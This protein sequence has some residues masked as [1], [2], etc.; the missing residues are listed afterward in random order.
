MGR[1]YQQ[2]RRMLHC[3]TLKLFISKSKLGRHW[4]KCCDLKHCVGI[5]TFKK[6]LT[7]LVIL[8]D[9]V[10]APEAGARERAFALSLA[11]RHL[12]SQMYSAPGQKVGMIQDAM[13]ALKRL[14]Y[15]K[16]VEDCQKL[17]LKVEKTTTA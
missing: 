5:L 6:L 7:N 16:G 1:L 15:H 13:G 9:K 3:K 14:G 10:A 4:T 2:W 8:A 11:C 17:L 12:P